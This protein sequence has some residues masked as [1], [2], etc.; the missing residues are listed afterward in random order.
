[1]FSGPHMIVSV[2]HLPVQ[3]HEILN[4]N[5]VF[6]CWLWFVIT[7]LGKKCDVTL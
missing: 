7:D 6:C 1:M 5:T 2:L 4:I 3:E